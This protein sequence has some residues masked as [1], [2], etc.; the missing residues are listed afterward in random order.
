MACESEIFYYTDDRKSVYFLFIFLF[1]KLAS[2][3]SDTI[4]DVTYGDCY[5]TGKY[6]GIS[7]FYQWTLR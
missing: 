7:V 4:R 2:L 3:V 5:N 6:C 1:S